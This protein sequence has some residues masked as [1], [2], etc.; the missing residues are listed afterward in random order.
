MRKLLKGYLTG[1]RH[2]T[3]SKMN[4]Q[5]LFW[6]LGLAGIHLVQAQKPNVLFVISD[7]LN[8]AVSGLGHPECKTPNLDHFAKSG[9]SFTEAYCQFPFCGPSRASIMTG[10]YP[11]VNGVMSNGGKVDPERIT[12]PRYFANHG[13]WSARVSKIYHMGIPVDIV[14]GTSGRDHAASWEE[15]HNIRAMETMTPGKLANYTQPEAGKHYPNERVNWSTAKAAKKPY[16]MHPSI[17]GDYAVVEVPDNDSNLLADTMAVDKAL[18]L[19]KKR[20]SKRNKD[21][22]FLAVGL[23]RPHFPFVST[24]ESLKPYDSH[25]MIYPVFPTDDHED[26][27]VG[28][29]GRTM[30]FKKSEVKELRRGYY[31]AVTYMDQQFGRLMAGLDKL[32]LRKNTIVVFV[33]D[34]GY[35]LGEH[36][37]WKKGILWNEAIHVPLIISAP[38]KRKGVRTNHIVELVD[39]YPTLTE[40]AGLP[41]EPNAQGQSLVP[42]LEDPKAELARKDAWITVAKGYALRSDKWAFMWYPTSKRNK[43][44]GFMLYDMEKD[45]QQFTNLSEKAEYAAIKAKLFQR[46]RN[47]VENKN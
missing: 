6:F 25:S 2:A 30:E 27:P 1:K 26:M 44:E 7:D 33:S 35:L 24:E 41:P 46:L 29:V 42:L 15:A 14:Q 11:T 12:L 21:P 9:V 37:M 23:V 17:R 8:Y 45:P 40:L 31:G 39:L 13:Y 34:H 43:R 36:K 5:L 32:E 18:G 10:Q 20:K 19:L 16:Q 3:H 47:R 28:A 38:G 22:F 4:K